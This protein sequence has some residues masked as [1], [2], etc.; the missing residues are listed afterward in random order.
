MR[1][2]A[3]AAHPEWTPEVQQWVKEGRL[4]PGMTTEAVQAAWGTAAKKTKDTA[5]GLVK[6]EWTYSYPKDPN[7]YQLHF[8]NGKLVT[9]SQD[10]K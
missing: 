10:K 1:S 3:L 5:Q 4:G 2:Q 7:V 8:E 9:W 6:E